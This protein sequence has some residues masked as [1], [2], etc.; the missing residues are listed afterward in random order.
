MSNKKASISD[1]GKLIPTDTDMLVGL[2][3]NPEKLINEEKRWKF[4]KGVALHNND[5]EDEYDDDNL[6]EDV[7]N[8]EEDDSKKSEKEEEEKKSIFGKDNKKNNSDDKKYDSKSEKSKHNSTTD[9]SYD[10]DETDLMAK[11]LDMLRQLGELKKCGVTL[12]QNYDMSSN[13]RDMQFEC[14]LHKDIKTKEVSV[15]WMSHMLIGLVRGVEIANDNFNPFEIKLSGLADTISSDMKNYYA[16]M[17]EI[18]EKYNKP[19]TNMNPLLKLFFMIT[20][21]ALT[22]QVNKALVKL[23]EIANLTG[24]TPITENET[25]NELRQKAMMDSKNNKIIETA[26]ESSNT[27]HD[28]VI[29][30]MA[31]LKMIKEKEIEYQ[32][33]K[34]MLD[35]KNADIKKFKK[36]LILSTEVPIY[37]DKDDEN[38][39][40]DNK[41]DLQYLNK[42]EIDNIR[43]MRYDTEAKHLEMMRKM[44]H[45]KSDMFRNTKT[46]PNVAEVDKNIIKRNLE[47]QNKALDDILMSIESKNNDTKSNM[48]TSSS[49]SINP[50][51][52]EIIKKTSNK[53]KMDNKTKDVKYSDFDKKADFI[54]E[55][56][57]SSDSDLY[58]NI[59][60]L[61]RDNISVGSSKNKKKNNDM[62]ANISVGSKT[63]GLKSNV[64][65]GKNKK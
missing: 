27:Q 24:S 11:K 57:A 13:L 37:S 65:I 43:K 63:K 19:G 29:Q 38:E 9:S 28:A 54:L 21:A 30:K 48:S 10:D 4:E 5:S 33:M 46:A 62:F 45:E 56:D 16:V 6:D 3:A 15:S 55:N 26:K 36:N 25:I 50:K 14:K 35:E 34:K 8:N 23:P 42:Q 52:G 41:N 20:G 64:N 59:T 12:S 7:D 44:A 31:D 53:V 18:Y 2:L 32:K 58:A 60:N 61:D 47:K 49:V 17:G 51:M 22:M 39:N 40:N 1:D